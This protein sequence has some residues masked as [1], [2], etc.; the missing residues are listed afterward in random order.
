MMAGTKQ[1]MMPAESTFQ[2]RN[3]HI[4][5]FRNTTSTIDQHSGMVSLLRK[6]FQVK[7]AGC[8]R[9]KGHTFHSSLSLLNDNDLIPY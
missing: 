5:R 9:I 6:T 7:D 3:L 1:P 2:P 4:G 8:K